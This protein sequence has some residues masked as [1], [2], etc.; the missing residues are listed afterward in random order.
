M[1]KKEREV[2]GREGIEEI[3]QGCRTCRLG[4]YDGDTPYVVPLSF[5]YEF[6]GDDVLELYFHCAFEGKK[7]DIL[8]HGNRVCFEISR[9]GEAIKGD[10]VCKWG[11]SYSSVIGYGEAVFVDG[12]DEKC[13]ALSS[14]VRRQSGLDVVFDRERAAGVCVFKVVSAEF[15]GKKLA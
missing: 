2:S 7:I 10:D 8:R 1:R 15:T 6:A 12:D 3:L 14:I 13:R 4:M 9:E 5:G 11:Y